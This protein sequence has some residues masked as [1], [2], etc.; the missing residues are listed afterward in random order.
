[1]RRDAKLA[2]VNLSPTD[3]DRNAQLVIQEGIDSVF[4]KIEI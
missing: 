2:I 1:M 3:A 4:S